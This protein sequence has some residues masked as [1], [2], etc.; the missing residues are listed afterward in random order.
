MLFRSADTNLIGRVRTQAQQSRGHFRERLE[1]AATLAGPEQARLLAE[2]GEAYDRYIAEMTASFDV[3]E[4]VDQ[5]A[6]SAD[7][8]AAMESVRA[9]REAMEALRAAITDYV[10][11][12]DAKGTTLLAGAETLSNT[13]RM[14]QIMAGLAV[15]VGGFV[16][17]FFLS[18]SG[19]DRK[20]VV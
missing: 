3:L 8:A 16:L 9:S 5:G 6:I 19:I 11:Y 20:S 4:T 10:D 13:V 14:I 17:A 18:R 1:Q 2:I 15:T 12:T 7:E